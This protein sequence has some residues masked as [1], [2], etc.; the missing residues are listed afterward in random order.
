LFV[1]QRM[2]ASEAGN[3]GEGVSGRW[4]QPSLHAEAVGQMSRMPSIQLV[5]FCLSAIIGWLV[6]IGSYW[7][8][9]R[10]YQ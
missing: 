3:V 6:G 9:S 10:C 7:C 2:D 1:Q 5:C 4:M 8:H